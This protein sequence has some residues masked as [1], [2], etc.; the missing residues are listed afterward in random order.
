MLH[1]MLALSMLSECTGDDLWSIEYCRQRGVPEAWI[2]ELLDGFE[3]NFA[4]DS[5]TIYV[6]D[7]RVNQYEGIRDVDLACKLGE[8]LGVD[9]A[10]LLARHF[11]RKQF[12]EAIREAI[13]EG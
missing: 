2:D 7:Q 4:V 10:N 1:R 6:D 9:T 12:V 3:S 13:E 11:S 8:F 5:R